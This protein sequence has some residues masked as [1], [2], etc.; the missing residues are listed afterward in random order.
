MKYIEISKCVATSNLISGLPIV[1]V[2]LNNKNEIIM[3]EEIKPK[4]GVCCT[5]D[6]YEPGFITKLPNNGMFY[7]IK[8]YETWE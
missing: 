1:M 8:Y 6:D 4:P 3:S 2:A 7:T 5:L